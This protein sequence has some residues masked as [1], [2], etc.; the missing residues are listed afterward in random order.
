MI[1]TNSIENTVAKPLNDSGMDRIED[2]ETID[3]NPDWREA[4]KDE[5]IA[6]F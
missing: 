3:P 6:K 1:N 4:L 5:L 2:P